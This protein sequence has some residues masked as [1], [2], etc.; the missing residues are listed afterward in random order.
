MR[1]AEAEHWRNVFHRRTHTGAR[2]NVS[3]VRVFFKLIACA[4]V[5]VCLSCGSGKERPMGCL[6][7]LLFSS[8]KKKK[9]K[10]I[11]FSSAFILI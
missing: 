6:I 8:F 11:Y 9:K 10:Y 7:K 5:H 3:V 2:T 4:C 1:R